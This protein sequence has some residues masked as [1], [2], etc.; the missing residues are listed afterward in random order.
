MQSSNKYETPSE[1][2]SHTCSALSV[3]LQQRRKTQMPEDYIH[4]FFSAQVKQ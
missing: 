1:S 4:S 2:N 3:D